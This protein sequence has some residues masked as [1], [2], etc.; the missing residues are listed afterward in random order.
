MK[1][2]VVRG[3]GCKG[4]TGEGARGAA[5]EVGSGGRGEG[6]VEVAVGRRGEGQ[7]REG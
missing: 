4:R 1:V 6:C 3:R 5:G 7:G 2:G